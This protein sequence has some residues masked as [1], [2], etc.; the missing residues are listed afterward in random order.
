MA[1]ATS[2]TLPNK[3]DRVDPR[4][5]ASLAAVYLIWGST[6][7]AMAIVVTEIPPFLQGSM[8]FSFAGLVMLM[9]ATKRGVPFPP[10]RDWLRIAPIGV[11][12]F[13]GGNAF[14]AIGTQTVTSG[15]AAIVC[16]MLPLWV[17]VLG[18]VN[19]KDRPTAREWVSLLLGFAGVMVLMGGPSLAGK[20]E[21]VAILL[22]APISWAI[23]SVLQRRLPATP[24]TND[25]FMLPAV[26]ML[27]GGAALGLL[28]A[29]SGERISTDT[30]AGA[31]AGLAYL[32]IAGSLIA[33][34]AYSWMLRNSRPAIATS[35]AYVNPIIAVLAGAAI[36]G[37]PLG[38]TTFI[39][40]AMIVI[41]VMLALRNG[42][43]RQVSRA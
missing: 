29:V 38:A 31:W 13:V 10:L 41:A 22:C 25:A 3:S 30:S 23:G 40:N 36:S 1:V 39:A 28:G 34:T 37:E 14:V 12:L 21:H 18:V 33:F 19:K 42:A 7:L 43:K 11:L 20:P 5:I 8:R 16:A 6:Y 27:C 4:L 2:P 35:Y 17:G 24:T 15:G 9:I 26:Q 32:A